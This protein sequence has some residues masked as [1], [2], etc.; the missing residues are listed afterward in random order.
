MK[1]RN[2]FEK[3][4]SIPKVYLVIGLFLIVLVS[5][6]VPSLARYKN[7]VVDTS[8]TVWDG[9]IASSYQGGDGS[10]NNPYVIA[11]ASQLAYFSEMLKATNYS[12]TYFVL[13]NDILLNDGVF[14]KTDSGVTYTYNGSTLY[15]GAYSNLLYNDEGR[16]S[17]NDKKLKAKFKYA[18]KLEI[19]YVLVIGEDEINTNTVNIKNMETGEEKKV[20][21][22]AEEIVPFV[23]S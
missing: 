8:V 20:K 3:I 21:L 4:K 19:P 1:G 14:N 13:S 6:G 11:N 15:V 5:V 23:S 9:S 22:E 17:L 2:F 7:R 16:S 12:N 18:N 10:S